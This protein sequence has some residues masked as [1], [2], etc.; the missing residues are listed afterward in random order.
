MRAEKRDK[1]QA[2]ITRG[3]MLAG[4]HVVD[5]SAVGKGF[6]DIVCMHD[7]R[8]I[9]IEIKNGT[10]P[11]IQRYL[12]AGSAFAHVG[13]EKIKGIL[14]PDQVAFWANFRG[15]GGIV[16]NVEQAMKLIKLGNK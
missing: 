1:N 8:T 15:A 16:N 5:T 13:G 4:V 9:L 7:R 14:T 3:L 2:E 11:E 6:P 12:P 10:G